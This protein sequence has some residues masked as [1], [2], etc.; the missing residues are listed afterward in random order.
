MS[1]LFAKIINACLG[2][3]EVNKGNAITQN[4]IGQNKNTTLLRKQKFF[5]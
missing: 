5:G 3:L 4:R 2:S 1:I